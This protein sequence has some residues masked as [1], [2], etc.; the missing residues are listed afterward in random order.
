MHMFNRKKSEKSEQNRLR[1][2]VSTTVA[3]DQDQINE[4]DGQGEVED[5]IDS[6]DPAVRKSK[7]RKRHIK[8]S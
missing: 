4:A 7:R 8:R 2:N 5:A 3:Q 6:Y 1:G